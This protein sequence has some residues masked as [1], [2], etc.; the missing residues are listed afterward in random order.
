MKYKYIIT[1]GCSLLIHFTGLLILS[2]LILTALP[3]RKKN[4][5]VTLKVIPKENKDID[6]PKEEEKNS[7][8]QRNKSK[9]NDITR[10]KG[11]KIKQEAKEQIEEPLK[12]N[13]SFSNLGKSL[14]DIGGNI[15]IGNGNTTDNEGDRTEEKRWV[16]FN[17]VSFD[18]ISRFP[19]VLEEA[20][21]EY[22]EEA[23]ALG[24]EADVKLK[25]GVSKKGE[26]VK[27]ELLSNPGWGFEKEVIRAIKRYKFAPALDQEGNPVDCYIIYIYHFRLK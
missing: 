26:V 16:R 6:L 25:I 27:V 21:A 17:P 7:D 15:G 10:N 9:K 8:E 4:I 11:K 1:S 19:M 3:Q 2:V 18:K 5:F 14:G 12:F 20:E 23:K 22:P 13:L 24:I